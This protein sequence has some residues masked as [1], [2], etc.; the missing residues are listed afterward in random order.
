MNSIKHF[1]FITLS[2]A[3]LTPLSAWGA[4]YEFDRAHSSFRFGVQHIFSTVYGHFDTYSGKVIFDPAKPAGSS[5][6]FTVKVKSIQTGIAKR[7][8][9]LLSKDFFAAGQYPEITFTS[10]SVKHTGGEKYE[11]SGVLQMKDV[12]KEVVLP[13]IY[14]GAK[15]HPM[16]T[17]KK[18]V[19]FDFNLKVD[20]LAYNVGNGNFHKMGVV[21]KDVTIFASLEMLTDN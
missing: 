6:Q 5:F 12:K 21:G 3:L 20:R 13:V 7:D 17:S 14:K 8:N 10:S 1:I 11:V 18:V 2:F 4:E 19:G 15:I 16:D 9:H